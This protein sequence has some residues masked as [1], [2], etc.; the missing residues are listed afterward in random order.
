MSHFVIS[1]D[2]TIHYTSKF[3]TP[4]SASHY[5]GVAASERGI[6]TNRFKVHIFPLTLDDLISLM[7]HQ[8]LGDM[9]SGLVPRTVSSFSAL[10]DYVDANCYGNLCD[11]DLADA[12]IEEFGGRDDNEG[13]PDGFLNL[14]NRAQNAVDAWLRDPAARM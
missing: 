10:H 11:D 2:G 9:E 6:E 4:E 7:K 3:S 1:L 12:Y 8:I 13:M 5:I 14:I